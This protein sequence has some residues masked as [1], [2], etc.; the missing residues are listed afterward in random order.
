MK[1]GGMEPAEAAGAEHRKDGGKNKVKKEEGRLSFCMLLQ[2]LSRLEGVL[3]EEHNYD[4]L[5]QMRNIKDIF[6]VF[7]FRKSRL[8]LMLHSVL[9]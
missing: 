5:F 7:K 3:H 9:S 8:R 4:L 2:T 6:T 1:D